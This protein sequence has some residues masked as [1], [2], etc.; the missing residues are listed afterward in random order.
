[1]DHNRHEEM[2]KIQ[3]QRLES[4]SANTDK[5]FMKNLCERIE[6]KID[7]FANENLDHAVDAIVLLWKL[8]RGNGCSPTEFPETVGHVRPLTSMTSR[9]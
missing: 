6:E 2:G 8:P 4:V 1:M 3:I 5:E 9:C 7:G